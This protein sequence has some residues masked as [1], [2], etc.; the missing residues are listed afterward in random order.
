MLNILSCLQDDYR[1]SLKYNIITKDMV[2]I[3]P[4]DMSGRF[5][6][7][8]AEFKGQH[9]KVTQILLSECTFSCLNLSVFILPIMGNVSSS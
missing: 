3:C 6:D 8:V 4:L 5:V 7:P 9:V 2:P 1:I